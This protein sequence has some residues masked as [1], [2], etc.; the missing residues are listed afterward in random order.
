MTVAIGSVIVASASAVAKVFVIGTIGYVAA[1]R[2]RPIPILPPHAMNAISKMNFDLLVLPLIYTT[3]ASAVT[4]EK[5]GSLW[6]IMVS[7][8]GVICL[9]YG[10]ASLLGMLPFFKVENKTD[11]DALRVAATFPNIIALPILIFPTLCEF[12][13]VYNSFYEGD[14]DDDNTVK[15]RSCTEQSNA[16]IFIYFFA[17]N[18]VYWI[19]GHPT[20]VAAGKKRQMNSE[21][22][23]TAMEHQRSVDSSESEAS[24]GDIEVHND[25]DPNNVSDRIDN[26]EATNVQPEGDQ[27][28]HRA[29]G[30][31][32]RSMFQQVANG[33]LKTFKSPGFLAMVLGFITACI[34][35]LRNALFSPGGALRFL[36]SALEA[37]GSASAAVGTLICAASLN[38]QASDDTPGA[39]NNDRLV[40]Q[41][42][43]EQ[44]QDHGEVS[45]SR[46]FRAVMQR[47][48]SSITQF[49]IKTMAAIRRRKPTIRMHTWF[50]FSRH[51]VT[52]AIV[53]LIILAMDCGSFLDDVPSLAK[54]VVIVNSGLPGAQLIV[55]TLKA[56]GLSDSASIVAKVYLPS[57]L[58]SVITIAAWTSL[59]LLLS[60]YDST[61]LCKR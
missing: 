58:L 27:M 59:G 21:R 54:M 56:K 17:W 22:L 50:F 2:P 51:I 42:Q 32:V 7:A 10:V 8:V 40:C 47:R 36:G 33:M 14:L 39:G 9:S 6:I 13:A 53:C 1:I 24:E 20:L 11:F 29:H 3:L 60:R 44:T 38:H 4:P 55:L 52:P 25:I 61:S 37:L 35:P 12:P 43:A 41:S 23:Q 16:M 48:R 31:R 19:F 28:I 26:E 30:T 57:Y 49:S 18:L 46:D 15:Y 34:P 5:L 45:T